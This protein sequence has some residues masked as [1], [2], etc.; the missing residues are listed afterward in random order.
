MTS[1]AGAVGR[2]VKV[3]RFVERVFRHASESFQ[4][5]YFENKLIGFLFLDVLLVRLYN[6]QLFTDINYHL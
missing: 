6:I 4:V 3:T 5:S 1:R 2:R